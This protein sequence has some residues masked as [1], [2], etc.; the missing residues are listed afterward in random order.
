MNLVDWAREDDRSGDAQSD[1]D[2]VL[3]VR[4]IAVVQPGT[5]LRVRVLDVVR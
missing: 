3:M 1:D 5:W 4:W 2:T